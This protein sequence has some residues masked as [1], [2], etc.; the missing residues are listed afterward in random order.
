MNSGYINLNAGLSF[1]RGSFFLM[2]CKTYTK[3]FRSEKV[4][5]RRDVKWIYEKF[6]TFI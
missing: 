5:N 1:Y 2:E 6:H 3:N 4:V